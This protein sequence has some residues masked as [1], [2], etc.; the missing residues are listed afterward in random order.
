MEKKMYMNPGIKVLA[1][2]QMLLNDDLSVVDGTVDGEN[3]LGKENDFDDDDFS[4]QL[5]SRHVWDD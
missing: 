1:T 4:F 5:K 2:G 3:V